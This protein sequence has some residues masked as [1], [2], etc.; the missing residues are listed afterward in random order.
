MPARDAVAE[1]LHRLLFSR[2]SVGY[3]VVG[4]KRP[5]SGVAYW[6]RHAF[7]VADVGRW[8]E[9]V[10]TLVR[11]NMRG[12]IW[13]FVGSSNVLKRVGTSA[14]RP[15][16]GGLRSWQA[17]V[18]LTWAGV[19]TDEAAV[20]FQKVGGTIVAAKSE[21]FGLLPLDEPRPLAALTALT[22]EVADALDATPL[23][24]ERGL[25]LVGVGGTEV[26]TD[27]AVMLTQAPVTAEAI[28]RAGL[29]SSKTPAVDA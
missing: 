2:A 9:A 28:V 6:D 23:G 25:P 24:Y 11:L 12:E 16:N 8:S 22:R 5:V 17:L 4:V 18:A 26:V 14:F 10:E 19:P 27:V 13:P 29:R 15:S 21:S 20:R 1:A 3:A 7:G